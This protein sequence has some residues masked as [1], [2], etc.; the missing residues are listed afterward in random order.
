MSQYMVAKKYLRGQSVDKTTSGVDKIA[1][2][3]EA[4]FLAVKE[5]VFLAE[6]RATVV[7]RAHRIPHSE[8]E[9]RAANCTKLA[10]H[11]FGVREGC[12]GIYVAEK[13]ITLGHRQVFSLILSWKYGQANKCDPNGGT[14]FLY[15][16]EKY[17][18]WALGPR[19]GMDIPKG[20]LV[21]GSAEAKR[22]THRLSKELLFA[23]KSEAV[24]PEEIPLRPWFTNERTGWF[25]PTT[26]AIECHHTGSPTPWPSPSPTPS[27]SPMPT[28]SPTPSPTATP[29]SSPTSTP[30]P[31]PT[32]SWTAGATAQLHG[33][34]PSLFLRAHGTAAFHDAVSRWI[35]PVATE[36]VV[37]THVGK[38]VYQG[39]V[40][41]TGIWFEVLYNGPTCRR[42][43]DRCTA[44]VLGKALARQ[45]AVG[46]VVLALQIVGF[47]D[48][49]AAD[50]SMHQ[51]WGHQPHHQIGWEGDFPAA[52]HASN[53]SAAA[54][55]RKMSDTKGWVHA[56]HAEI[57]HHAAQVPTGAVGHPKSATRAT[58]GAAGTGV[59]A[60]I[61]VVA[62]LAWFRKR[63]AMSVHSQ[64]SGA[65]TA[66]SQPLRAS[67]RPYQTVSDGGDVAEGEMSVSM[68][69]APVH[70]GCGS[71]AAA[72]SK[73]QRREEELMI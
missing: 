21:P 9:P 1:S 41:G 23:A 11:P 66:E 16:L 62:A 64:R 5:T 27:P 47:R 36:A 42:E 70:S 61:V 69:N 30:T 34:S 17:G 65:G 13:G 6:A 12:A 63:A 51:L 39:I 32:P 43:P 55:T 18:L 31:V 59:F 26:L 50:L 29:T 14:V 35:D 54:S 22:E 4:A 49:T 53:A 33:V 73:E 40:V 2:M 8:Q 57:P 25:S 60:V 15:Y 58:T 24:S 56:N 72:K 68:V 52:A 46:A 71:V 44:Q 45:E 3:K 28:P 7:E 37:I 48:L 10:V 67:Q 19:A 38:A 20:G